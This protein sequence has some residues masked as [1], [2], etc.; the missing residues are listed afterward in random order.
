MFKK[1]IEDDHNNKPRT[2]LHKQEVLRALEKSWPKL[3]S[4][5]IAKISQKDCNDWAA[6]HGKD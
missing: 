1:E 6:R 3:Y 5:D 4:K 2:K